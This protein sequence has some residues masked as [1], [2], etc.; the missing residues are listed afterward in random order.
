MSVCMA[1]C[2]QLSAAV[3]VRSIVVAGVLSCSDEDARL[4]KTYAQHTWSVHVSTYFQLRYI[5]VLW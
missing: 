2:S 4:C 3:I 5:Y 1:D